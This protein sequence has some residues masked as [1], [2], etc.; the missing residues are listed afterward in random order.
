MWWFGFPEDEQSLRLA[1]AKLA[2]N[3]AICSC[4]RGCGNPRRKRWWGHPLTIQERKAEID[5]LDQLREA[6]YAD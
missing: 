2:D 5:A 6:G 3:I 1:A 4:A